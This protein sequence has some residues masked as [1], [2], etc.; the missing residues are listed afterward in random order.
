VTSPAAPF[1]NRP[2]SCRP[3]FSLVELMI[4]IVILGLGMVMVATMFP[5][6]WGRARDL[7][8]FTTSQT[9]TPVAKNLSSRLLRAAPTDLLESAVGPSFAGDL[10]YHSVPFPPSSPLIFDNS[11]PAPFWLREPWVHQLNMQNIRISDPAFVDEDPYQ[12][13]RYLDLEPP[14]DPERY[15]D[16]NFANYDDAPR[17]NRD[18]ILESSYVSYQIAA[19]QRVFPPLRGRENVDLPDPDN[20]VL[21]DTSAPDN[22]WDDAF[23]TR[24]FA[25][26]VF[27]RLQDPVLSFEVADSNNN[28]VPQKIVP[29]ANETRLVDLYFVTLRRPRSTNRYARQATGDNI[30]PDPYFLTDEPVTPAAQSADED[31]LLPVAWRVQISV[32]NDPVKLATKVS[33][34]NIPTE[35]TVP[36]DGFTGNERARRMLVTMFPRGTMFIDEIT[37]RVYTVTRVRESLNGLSA[38]LTLDQEILVDDI[39]IPKLVNQQGAQRE[40]PRCANCGPIVAINPEELLRTV[41]VFPPPVQDRDNAEEHPAFAGSTPVVDIDIRTISFA[42]PD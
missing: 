3:A 34:T 10:M 24:R 7:S 30:L 35:V 11:N 38:T 37:G 41:W 16:R 4:A 32:K 36:P 40:D 12:L 2:A 27:H 39:N 19:H 21:F 8:E 28:P 5:V 31:V 9:I 6:A 20:V 17:G 26:A 33:P 22:N 18:S 23:A 42:P 29:I 15:L 1:L 25:W 13:E 14:D